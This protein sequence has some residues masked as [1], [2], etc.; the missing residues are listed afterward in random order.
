M[1]KSSPSL[2]PTKTGIGSAAQ[3]EKS[4]S[5][6]NKAMKDLQ[7]RFK[8]TGNPRDFAELRKLQIQKR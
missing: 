7:A 2:N 5:K 6:A 3:S 1:T 4:P 8:Q